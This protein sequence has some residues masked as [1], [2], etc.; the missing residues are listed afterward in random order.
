[1]DLA[2]KTI[3]S[4]LI[5]LIV[6][7]SLTGC[8]TYRNNKEGEFRKGETS[9]TIYIPKK[10]LHLGYNDE[11]SPRSNKYYTLQQN[12]GF[13][14]I[15][16]YVKEYELTNKY[17]VEFIAV[18]AGK[19]SIHYQFHSCDTCK[20]AT[21]IKT[22]LTDQMIEI[23]TVTAEISAGKT[24]VLIVIVGG[25]SAFLVKRELNNWNMNFNFN[26]R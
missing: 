15:E 14:A 21:V 12:I 16:R 5:L 23:E 10:A 8:Y 18:I 3:I 25:V 11:F 22:Y 6:L 1:M 9:D 4:F 13:R 20:F 24:I 19:D 17:P 7:I 26:F 2:K